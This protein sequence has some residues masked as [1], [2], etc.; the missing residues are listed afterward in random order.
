MFLV[1]H[2]QKGDFWKSS[3]LRKGCLEKAECN[4]DFV[5][6]YVQPVDVIFNKPTCASLLSWELVQHIFATRNVFL[7]IFRFLHIKWE[8]YLSPVWR[9]PMP[10]CPSPKVIAN[11]PSPGNQFVVTHRRTHTF[12]FDG[13]W[14]S[15][16]R[17]DCSKNCF[18]CSTC[19]R[20]LSISAP[21]RI[22]E[23]LAICVLVCSG[24]NL[25]QI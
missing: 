1:P 8:S 5:R 17:K 14:F 15:V 18:F 23:Q 10:C 22:V 21:C 24:C 6:F 7:L 13:V 19:S 9:K 25:L 11:A 3:N 2:R 4:S 20:P 16:I 12:T